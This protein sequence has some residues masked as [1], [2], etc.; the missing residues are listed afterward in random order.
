MKKLELKNRVEKIDVYGDVYTIEAGSLDHLK[1]MVKFSADVTEAIQSLFEELKKSD[2]IQASVSAG[3]FDSIVKVF[4]VSMNGI[5][6]KGAW[7]KIEVKCGGN[8]HAMID[9]VT[10][11]SEVVTEANAYQ[12]QTYIEVKE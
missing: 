7:K 10:F 11:V 8:L 9:A 1:K 5:L 12:K 2:D 6:G 4:R 3:L